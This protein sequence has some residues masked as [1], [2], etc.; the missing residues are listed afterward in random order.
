MCCFASS[1]ESQDFLRGPNGRKGHYPYED[2]EVI[3]DVWESIYGYAFVKGIHPQQLPG[4]SMNRPQAL[5][6]QMLGSVGFIFHW[7]SLRF[8]HFLQSFFMVFKCFICSDCPTWSCMHTYLSTCK[9]MQ[10]Y[11]NCTC[12]ILLYHFQ[13]VFQYYIILS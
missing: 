5:V 7:G 4:V 2:L 10:T 6:A 12:C 13:H 9:H 1:V 11:A 3:G 8:V